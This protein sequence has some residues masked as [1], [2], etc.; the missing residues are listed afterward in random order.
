MKK[1][2][3]IRLSIVKWVMMLIFVLFIVRLFYL[4]VY[5]Y[6][7]YKFRSEGQLNRIVKLF[8][9]RGNIYDRNGDPLA[10]TKTSYSVY[11]IPP[12]IENKWDFAKY[13]AEDIDIKSSVILKKVQTKMPFVWIQRKVDDDVYLSLKKRN[14]EGL[15]FIKEEKRVYPNQILAGDV[16]GFVGIDN[17]GLAG[18][19]YV[20][21]TLLKGSPGKILLEGDPIGRQLI[22][23]K[24]RIIPPYDGG[25]ITT[26]LDKRIQYSAEKHL[27]D[28]VLYNQAIS[29]QVIVMDP[30]NGDILAMADYPSFDPNNYSE[31]P[32]KYRKNSCVTDVYEPGSVFKIITV[33]AVLEE[34]IVTPGAVIEVPEEIDF[35]GALVREAHKRDEEDT[36]QKTVSDIIV[37]SLNVGTTLLADKLG[38]NKLYKY[39][40]FFGFGKLT[41]IKIAGE[42]SGLLR[43]PDIWSGVDVAMI[44]FGQGLAVTPLQLA[45]AVS[46]IA[47][48]GILL[49]PRIIRN[50][51]FSNG[52]TVKHRPILEV[53][54]PISKK[55]AKEVV[56]IMTRV[57]D[58]GTGQIARIPG[59]SIAGKTGTAQKARKDGRGYEKGKYV[60]SFLGFFPADDPKILILVVVDSPERKIWGSSVAGP[61]FKNIALD[62]IDHLNILPH[63]R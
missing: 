51:N 3:N 22:S 54:R 26:T 34:D 28:G 7:F 36:D 49:R 30:R 11:A 24:R 18:L 41:G 45:C 50:I 53:E 10:L 21:D 52:R 4:Q 58:E 31:Y 61:I 15:N 1:R 59:Y 42:S 55:T 37:E 60:A 44:S 27:K 6:K 13:L 57:V 25:H 5:K 62:T 35:N 63:K 12:Q 9:H 19:E 14:I 33:A 48:D 38:K 8:P 46:A 16:L 40:R 2:N 47:N 32:I 39:S 29:G 56:K 17:Q 23:G 20:Q 43:R